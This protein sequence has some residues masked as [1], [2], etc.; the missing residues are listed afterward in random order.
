MAITITV[1]ADCC[2]LGMRGNQS[3]VQDYLD[4]LLT[5][6][7]KLYPNEDIRINFESGVSGANN[8]VG[9]DDPDVI[10]ALT[11][12]INYVWERGNWNK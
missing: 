3:D 2:G 11:D 10:E 4:E 9:S 7:Q 8:V 1:Y 6:A 12:L 5:E